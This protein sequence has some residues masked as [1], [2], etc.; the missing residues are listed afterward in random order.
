MKYILNRIPSK[1]RIRNIIFFF[2]KKDIKNVFGQ[3][4]LRSKQPHIT[5]YKH[6]TYYWRKQTDEQLRRKKCQ[7]IVSNCSTVIL[8]LTAWLD[9][10]LSNVLKYYYYLH[11]RAENGNICSFSRPPV[12]TASRWNLSVFQ[13]P[14]GKSIQFSVYSM[15][16]YIY[17]T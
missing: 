2:L 14:D 6:I 8:F 3:E 16:G 17:Y 13:W 5:Y 7:P 12:S 9:I 15:F 10:W 1:L 11:V 4:C